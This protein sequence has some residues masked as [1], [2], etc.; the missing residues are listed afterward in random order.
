MASVVD[1]IYLYWVEGLTQKAIEE[2]LDVGNVSKQLIDVGWGAEGGKARGSLS[3]LKD[4]HPEDRIKRKIADALDEGVQ[5]VHFAKEHSPKTEEANPTLEEAPAEE[6]SDFA[7]APEP[8]DMLAGARKEAVLS[9]DLPSSQTVLRLSAVFAA[10]FTVLRVVT[11][12]L[13]GDRK[14]LS[15]LLALVGGTAATYVLR[16]QLPEDQLLLLEEA[17]D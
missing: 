2:K 5:R 7:E 4:D 13:L 8:Q 11:G 17:S 10:V 9:V 12:R 14:W 6:V 16:G 1:I 15:R 3:F